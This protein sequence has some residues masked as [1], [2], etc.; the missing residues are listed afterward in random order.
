MIDLRT[1]RLRF[2]LVVIGVVALLHP[3][4]TAVSDDYKVLL[5]WFDACVLAAL[6]ILNWSL[7]GKMTG[8]QVFFGLVIVGLPLFGFLLPAISMGVELSRYEPQGTYDAFESAYTFLR[9]PQYWLVGSVQIL[10][11]LGMSLWSNVVAPR[12]IPARES[13]SGTP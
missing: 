12:W 7:V 1:L 5:S 10:V 13:A 8:W 11:W 9:F 2:P 4:L 3:I 6:V